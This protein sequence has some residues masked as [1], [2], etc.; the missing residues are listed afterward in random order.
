MLIVI[1]ASPGSWQRRVKIE[2]SRL[3]V[4]EMMPYVFGI[5]DDSP[6][7]WGTV[8]LY[9][10]NLRWL[11]LCR[12]NRGIRRRKPLIGKFSALVHSELK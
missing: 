12:V 3:T 4:T 10:V 8:A 9:Y 2:P 6:K 5:R 7:A 1:I 11:L